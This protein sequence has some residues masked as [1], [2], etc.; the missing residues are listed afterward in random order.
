ML[1][2]SSLRFIHHSFSSLQGDSLEA[3]DLLV[4]MEEGDE[5]ENPLRSLD[6]GDDGSDE[7][8]D[9][10]ATKLAAEPAAKA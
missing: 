8:D 3:G 6:S 2:S 10:D 7:T 5:P 1:A 4:S 9:P